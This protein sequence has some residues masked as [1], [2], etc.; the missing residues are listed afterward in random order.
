MSEGFFG[1]WI[2]YLACV[3]NNLFWCGLRIWLSDI[4]SATEGTVRTFGQF[5]NWAAVAAMRNAAFATASLDYYRY[6]VQVYYQQIAE[7][8]NEIGPYL[9][10]SL[11]WFPA[12]ATATANYAGDLASYWVALSL[13]YWSEL[14]AGLGNLQIVVSTGNIWLELLAALINLLV[15]LVYLLI[16][17][18]SAMVHWIELLFGLLLQFWGLLDTPAYNLQ[19]LIFGTGYGPEPGSPDFLAQLQQAGINDGKIYLFLV[20]GIMLGDS[21]GA[22]LY[23]NYAIWPIIAYVGYHLI[24]WTFKQ[25]TELMPV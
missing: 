10:T 15:A 5:G 1:P 2:V 12:A 20:W 6:M 8:A 16:Q 21:V 19:D 25:L 22:G 9:S 7:R 14:A 18:V 23:L 4:A 17:V 3:L 13:A 24:I 11:A